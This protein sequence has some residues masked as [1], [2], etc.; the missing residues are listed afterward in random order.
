MSENTNQSIIEF[1]A[2]AVEVISLFRSR[3]DIRYYLTGLCVFPGHDG[4]GCFVTATNGHQ[5]G[6]WFDPMGVC[7]EQTAF[8]V[9][10]ELVAACEAEKKVTKLARIE[11]GRLVVVR[12]KDG[13]EIFVLPGCAYIKD[14][15]QYPDVFKVIPGN[16]TLLP[17]LRGNIAYRYMKNISKAGLLVRKPG[18]SKGG[19]SFYSNTEAGTGAS[20]AVFEDE[21]NLLVVTMAICRKDYPAQNPIPSLF[22]KP[23]QAIEVQ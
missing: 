6:V 22:I 15:K 5:L 7:H 21:K 4:K 3:G 16:K 20:V 19:V 10:K 8:V 18:L 1:D 13:S 9:S 17:G 2:K 11:D 23:D 14:F 12:E